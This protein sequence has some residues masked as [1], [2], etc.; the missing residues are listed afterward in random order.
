MDPLYVVTGHPLL[1]PKFAGLASDEARK[2]HNNLAELLLGLKAPA[3]VGDD[4]TKLVMAVVL[5]INFQLERGLDPL[6][7]KSISNQH[8]GNTTT[9]RDRIVSPEA[10]A[11]V[12]KVTGARQV[13]FR[14]PSY[15][16]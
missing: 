10:A 5:Q 14:V 2:E 6:V 1:I 16:V 11:I 8:P 4:A 9:Y 13:A 15:G 7:N 3:Y 12:E